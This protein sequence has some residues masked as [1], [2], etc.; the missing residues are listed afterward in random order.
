MN[1]WLYYLLNI[2][3]CLLVLFILWVYG[4]WRNYT[5]WLDGFAEGWDAARHPRR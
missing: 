4:Y 5:G 2:A 3:A 1:P